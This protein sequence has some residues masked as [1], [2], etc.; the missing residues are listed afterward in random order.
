MLYQQ[1]NKKNKKVATFDMNFDMNID[2]SRDFFIKTK[3]LIYE[4]LKKP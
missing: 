4:P 1:Y 2:K 3:W